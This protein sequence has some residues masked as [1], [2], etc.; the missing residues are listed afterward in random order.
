[1]S[2]YPPLPSRNPTQ[3]PPGAPPP[4]PT[5]GYATPMP[6]GPNL[7]KIAANQRAIN[8][9]ILAEIFIVIAQISFR[10]NGMLALALV[11]S[12]AYLAIALTG[13]VFLFMLSLSLYNTAA[14]IAL[15][16]FSLVPL[17]GLIILL[18]LNG[19]ATNILRLHGIRV[20]LL[21]ADPSKIPPGVGP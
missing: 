19:K 6:P 17:L 1:M 7:K 9:C 11:F 5:L 20:G 8:L 16:I 14:G 10:T 12:F 2:Q 3:S 4:L 21:G 18:V 13:A 15:G